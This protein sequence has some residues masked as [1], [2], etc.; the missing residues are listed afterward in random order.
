M[1]NK[2]SFIFLISFCLTLIIFPLSAQIPNGFTK[3][4]TSINTVTYSDTTCPDKTTCYYYV[5]ATDS[6]GA[7]SKLSNEG[8]AVIPDTGTHTVTLNW[9]ASASIN[10]TYNVYQHIGPLAPTGLVVV[11]N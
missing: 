4:A 5:T 1:R 10:V 11:T 8:T 3:I 2:F 7:E 9:T 6:T